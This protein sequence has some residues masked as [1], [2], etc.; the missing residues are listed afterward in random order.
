MRTENRR[1]E[2]RD[3]AARPAPTALSKSVRELAATGA[4]LITHESTTHRTALNTRTRWFTAMLL[5]A[6]SGLVK[7]LIG[8]LL[9]LITGGIV[10]Y[11]VKRVQKRL[12]S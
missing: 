8:L 6:A 10:T 5:K 12:A 4:R 3:P 2:R 11:E 7:I 9:A 1:I